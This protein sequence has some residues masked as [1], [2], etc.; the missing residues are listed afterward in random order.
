MT[1]PRG[2]PNRISDVQLATFA[3]LNPGARVHLSVP[4]GI[5]EHKQIRHLLEREKCERRRGADCAP[6]PRI[7]TRREQR[8]DDP[9]ISSERRG[10]ERSLSTTVRAGLICAASKQ[11]LHPVKARVLRQDERS[12][13]DVVSQIHR[14][15]RTEL[16]LELIGLPPTRQVE[17]S[18]P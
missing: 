18:Y 16:R 12:V 8:R 14:D 3:T 7:A 6:A 11:H 10:A 1:D 9:A 2:A 13:A 4:R 15:A 17:Q 5:S